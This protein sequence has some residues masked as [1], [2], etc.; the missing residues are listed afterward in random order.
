MSTDEKILK[1]IKG[2]QEGDNLSFELLAEKY[3]SVVVS[4]SLSIA[5]SLEGAGLD[6]SSEVIEDLQ[7]EARLALYKAAM[8][9]DAQG[10]GESVTFGLYAKI[11]IKN[12]LIS[13]LRRRKAKKRR[14][15][16]LAEAALRNEEKEVARAVLSK[17]ELEAV[18]KDSRELLSR[19]EL[20]V[21]MEYAEGNSVPEISEKFGKPQKSVNNALYR[22]RV[23]LRSLQMKF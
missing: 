9:Y 5:K 2:T 4:S 17:V 21:L 23:K 3:N 16:R 15:I 12:C 10:L 20:A 14:E 11:C 22:I 8:K 1:L 13:E 19:Y 18:L 7:Q 6:A